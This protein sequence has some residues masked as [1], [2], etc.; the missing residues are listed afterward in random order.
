[1]KAN[2]TEHGKS[3]GMRKKPPVNKGSKLGPR[4]G[5]AK[6][7]AYKPQELGYRFFGKCYNCGSEG[8]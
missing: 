6:K 2:V 7:L 1:M 5:V 4:G 3:S 8:F